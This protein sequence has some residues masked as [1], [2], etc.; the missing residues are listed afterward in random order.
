MEKSLP[1][2]ADDSPPFYWYFQPNAS[3]NGQSRVK[4]VG[5]LFRSFVGWVAARVGVAF[6]PEITQHSQSW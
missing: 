4:E 2:L 3:S 6:R 1:L 5:F